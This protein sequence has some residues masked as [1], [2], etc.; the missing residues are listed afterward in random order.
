MGWKEETEV[1]GSGKVVDVWAR[2]TVV[3][4]GRRLVNKGD[5]GE[6]ASGDSLMWGLRETEELRVIGIPFKV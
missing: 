1:D 3:G 5:L 2:W 6:L 4:I